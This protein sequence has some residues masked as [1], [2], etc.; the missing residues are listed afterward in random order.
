MYSAPN[1]KV[2]YTILGLHCDSVINNITMVVPHLYRWSGELQD[3]RESSV[4][5]E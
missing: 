4:A 2:K 5:D 3:N 1:F